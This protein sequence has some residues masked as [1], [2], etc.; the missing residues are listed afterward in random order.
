VVDDDGAA[1]GQADGAAV[2]RGDLGFDVEAGEEGHG[3]GVEFE[4]DL[5]ARHH[6][7]DVLLRLGEELLVVDQDFGDLGVEVVAQRV[8]Q[9]VLVVVEQFRLPSLR[10]VVDHGLPEALQD[11][12]VGP[13]VGLGLLGGVGAD[14]DALALVQIEILRLLAQLASQRLV[15]DLAG[16]PAL[17]VVREVDEK[18]PARLM[19]V[20]SV[21]PLPP[22]ASRVTCTT[23][24]CP[25]WRIWSIGAASP[26]AR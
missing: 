16:D 22:S 25:F 8:D 2:D 4:R 5:R 15:L 21:A 11:L 6:R 24:G 1:A 12:Q 9:Q 17:R 13:Q 3:F 14:D 26:A 20:V 23:M 19:L 7:L 10:R 18:R